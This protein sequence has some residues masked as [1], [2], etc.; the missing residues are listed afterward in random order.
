MAF[1]VS[2]LGKT[3]RLQAILK[4]QTGKNIS[5]QKLKISISPC[6]PTYFYLSMYYI[7]IYYLSI[8][9]NLSIYILTAIDILHI[10]VSANLPSI[11]ILTSIYLPTYFY[12][13]T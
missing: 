5:S 11:Y 3:F 1:G 12:L 6:L 13:S 7:Y 4:W 10:Y 2:P 8:Y 9:C